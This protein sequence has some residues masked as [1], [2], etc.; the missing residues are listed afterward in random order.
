[1]VTS[2]SANALQVNFDSVLSMENVGMVKMFKT[3]EETGLK[4]FLG[5]QCSVYEGEVIEFFAN[6]KVIAGTIVSFVA[7]RKMVITKDVFA[8]TFQLPTEGM[9]GFTDLPAKVV[10]EMKMRFSST[11]VAFRPPNKKKEIKFEYRLLHDIVAKALCAKAGSFDVVTS[12]KF[13]LMVAISAGLK[14]SLLLEKVVKANLGESVKLH[15]LKVLKNKSALTYMKK[16]IAVEQAGEPSKPSTDTASGDEGLQSLTNRPVKEIVAKKKI[17]KEKAVENKQQTVL[18][19]RKPVVAGSQAAPE[20][21]KS[22]TSLDEESRPLSKLGPVKKVGAAPKR[23]LVLDSYDS[24]STISLPLVKI[25]KKQRTKRT[26]PVNKT[27]GDQAEANPG[28]ATEIPAEAEDVSIASAPKKNVES[29]EAVEAQDFNKDRSIVVRTEL[30]QPSQQPMTCA[31]KG[32]FALVEI[33]EINWA[34]HFPS[35]IDPASK[36]KE[37]LEAYALPN[38]WRSTFCCYS[39]QIGKIYP[40]RCVNMISGHTSALSMYE[41]ELKKRVDE[42]QANF[43]LAEPALRILDCLPLLAAESSV[44]GSTLDDTLQITCTMGRLVFSQET[45]APDPGTEKQ[46]T[47]EAEQRILA[48]ENQDHEE[49]QP[50]PELRRRMLK[51]SHQCSN[52]LERLKILWS[53][54]LMSTRLKREPAQEAEYAD[55]RLAQ[56][57]SSH[58]SPIHSSFSVHSSTLVRNNEDHQGT[59]PSSLQMV[60]Y[61][62]NNSEEDEEDFA[63]DMKRIVDSMD[64][65]VD[66]LR[67]TQAYR[68]MESELSGRNLSKK[69]DQVAV[70]F[71]SSQTA[72]ETSLVRQ[73]TEH[74]MQVNSDLYFVKMQLAELVNHFKEMSDAKKR[75]GP[76]SKKRRLL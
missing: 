64:S 5:V 21:S 25:T 54:L 29:T 61:T 27:A 7:N 73:F 43:D 13:D 22:G 65:K 72:L 51:S 52:I 32:I 55:E 69:I 46:P 48:I 31:S 24:K 59:S 58:S 44:A 12:K 37:I 49:E 39:T 36:G 66:M 53:K 8:V 23:K 76:S 42:H 40:T 1:M 2:L 10:S 16:N 26:N 9:V 68:K 45:E 30:E 56:A 33:R 60:R 20:K 11:D 28:P 57:G 6:A 14:L 47:K 62:D 41:T 38:Q 70:N 19:V 67:D 15:P 34:T 74:Q 18:V 75:E 50:A 17:V 3:M 35:K 71:N 63:Q 4:G